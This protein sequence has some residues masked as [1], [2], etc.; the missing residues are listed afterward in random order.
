MGDKAERR[1]KWVEDVEDQVEQTFTS[2]I[3]LVEP[4]I[5]PYEKNSVRAKVGNERED[6][7]RNEVKNES[8]RSGLILRAMSMF[9]FLLMISAMTNCSRSVD[10]DI[11]SAAERMIWDSNSIENGLNVERTRGGDELSEYSGIYYLHADLP[12]H[13]QNVGNTHDVGDLLKVQPHESEE[14][15]CAKW[16]QFD[17]DEH[18]HGEVSG[19][20]SF[21]VHNIYFHIW[22]KSATEEATMGVEVHGIYDSHTEYSFQSSHQ[23]A[24]ATMYRNGYWLTTE[25]LEVDYLEEDIHDM[26]IK[27]VSMDAIPSVFSGVNQYS[28]VILNLEDD[29]VLKSNDRDID[30]ISDYD[31]LFLHMTNPYDSDTDS[32]GLTDLE[33]LVDGKDGVS[34]DPNNFDMDNDDLPDSEDP[35]PTVSHFQVV[36]DEWIVEGDEVVRDAGLIVRNDITILDGGTLTIQDSVLMMNQNGEQKRIRVESGG[37]LNLIGNRLLTDNPAHWYSMTLNTGHWHEERN[38]EILGK[39]TILDNVIDYGCMIYIR[40][41]ND[42]VIAGNT[43]LHYYYGIF[44]S[45][46]SPRID[47]NFISPFIGNGIFLWHSSPQITNTVIVTYI[48]TGISLYYSSPVIRD[49]VISGGSND[50]F[51]SGG[52]H[53]IVSNTQFN[54]SMVHIDDDKSSLLVGTFDSYDLQTGQ[55][56]NAGQG[57]KSINIA[58]WIALILITF[59]VFLIAIR[60]SAVLDGMNKSSHGS[61]KSRKNRSGKARRRNRRRR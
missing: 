56:G 17:F 40:F 2:D 27:V 21:M 44:S 32:D 51:L 15:Y 19:D 30:G 26:S 28:F 55:T 50:F 12:K 3:M 37:T 24:S 18:V 29:A 47:D 31:E 42:T 10:Y 5:A 7:V 48:G 6:H 59:I 60:K 46:S 13:G 23:E 38:I 53:P 43:I 35:D 36:N 49:C 34:T 14:R 52:S 4:K 20:E 33:E 45:H 57:P 16:V 11:G 9:T 22:W 39:A 25:L 1:L 58:L 54:S 41:S 61:T 8:V